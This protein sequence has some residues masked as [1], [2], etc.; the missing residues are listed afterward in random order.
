M[1]SHSNRIAVVHGGTSTESGASTANARFIVESLRRRGADAFP[2]DYGEQIVECLKEEKPCLVFICVQGKGHGDGTIQAMLDFLKLPYTGSSAA[3]A[4]V[5]ND[6]I[7]CKRLFEWAGAATPAWRTLSKPEWEAAKE[8]GDFS[9]FNIAFPFVAKAPG[10]GGSF[11]IEYI[12]DARACS[13]IEKVFAYEDPILLERFITGDFVTASILERDG[14]P[15]ILPLL[16]KIP[17]PARANEKILLAGGNFSV[18][19]YDGAA[20]EQIKRGSLNI[21]NATGARGYA[22]IDFMVEAESEKAFAL[23]INAVP[24]LKPASL[25]PRAAALAGIDYDDMIEIIAKREGL[26]SEI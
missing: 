18:E 3:A 20:A 4:A 10:Q 6:K 15:E 8:T 9:S 1:F 14:K 24:G 22:R 2:L 23:E 17:D 5:I 25:F 21:Y 12:E 13:N 16:R 11:G 26:C 19:Q 7:L